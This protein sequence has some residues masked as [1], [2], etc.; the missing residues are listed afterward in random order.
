MPIVG[1]LLEDGVLAINESLVPDHPNAGFVV[2]EIEGD[3][4]VT[5]EFAIDCGT[6][7]PAIA[8]NICRCSCLLSTSCFECQCLVDA[9]FGFGPSFWAVLFF[10]RSPWDRI[11]RR[12]LF[13][14]SIRHCTTRV[15]RSDKLV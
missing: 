4:K 11:N 5:G 6:V 12:E 2:I 9:L 3:E 10:L 14:D 15:I 8:R 13:I 7:M 1:W